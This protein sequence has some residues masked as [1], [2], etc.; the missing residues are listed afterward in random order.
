MFPPSKKKSKRVMVRVMV[1][2]ATFNN[3]SVIS[4]RSFLLVKET[5]VSGKTTDLSQVT[6]TFY[7]IILY[8]VRLAISRIQTHNFSCDIQCLHR[9]L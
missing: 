1:F 6:D 4:W 3:I 5:V 7:H 2:N 8:R 9:Y